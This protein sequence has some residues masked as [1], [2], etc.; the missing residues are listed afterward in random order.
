MMNDRDRSRHPQRPNQ[1]GTNFRSSQDD[2]EID[3]LREMVAIPSPSGQEADLAAYLV[4]RMASLGFDAYRD[5]VGNAVGELGEGPHTLLFLGHMDTVPGQ[6]PVRQDGERL[7]GRGTVDAKGP[8]AAFIAAAARVGPLPGWRIAVVGAV[9]EERTISRGARHL[10]SAFEPPDWCI[11]GEPS[12]WNRITLGYKG[13]LVV[14]VRLRLPL[15]HSAGPSQLPAERAV[16]LWN[17]I[18]ERSATMNTG[19]KSFD[20]LTPSLYHITTC[21]DGAYG[22][23]NMTIGFRL[24]PSHTPQAAIQTLQGW[25]SELNLGAS[26]GRSSVDA[27]AELQVLGKEVAYRAPKNTPLVRTFLSAIRTEGGKPS[28][29]LKLGTSDMNVVGPAWQCPT[30]AYGPGDAKLDHTPDEHIDLSE[31]LRAIDVLERMLRSL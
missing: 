20:R 10:L 18:V 29:V 12:G 28:F 17:Q 3:L 16:D 30:V 7:Y 31:Y 19:C 27:T 22:I 11:I 9:E 23:V 1:A 5:A 25:L 8:L 24:P 13:S 15:A 21:D 6:I 4:E 26:T 14:Q 2:W